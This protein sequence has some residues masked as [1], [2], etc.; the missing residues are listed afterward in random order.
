MKVFAA[1]SFLFFIFE[2]GPTANAQEKLDLATRLE[3]RVEKS[4]VHY[5]ICR[6][7]ECKVL[8]RPSGHTAEELQT[9]MKSGVA[10]NAGPLVEQFLREGSEAPAHGEQIVSPFTATI[11]SEGQ[12]YKTALC[13][14]K[15][16]IAAFLKKAEGSKKEADYIYDIK[17]HREA[18]CGANNAVPAKVAAELSQL[19]KN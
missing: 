3:I 12:T 10:D 7:A 6:L 18:G 2:I 4:K 11:D 13:P 17:N 19:L 14:L 15:P 16:A 1:L 8:G 5:K 9:K